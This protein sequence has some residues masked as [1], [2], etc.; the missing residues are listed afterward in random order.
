MSNLEHL[1]FHRH[2]WKITHFVVVVAREVHVCQCLTYEY[3][4]SRD[5][6]SSLRCHTWKITRFVVTRQV[7]ISFYFLPLLLLLW[8]ALYSEHVLE[9]SSTQWNTYE[10]TM[11]Y[12]L[13]SAS[14]FC[15]RYASYVDSFIRRLPTTTLQMCILFNVICYIHF[16]FLNLRLVYSILRISIFLYVFFYTFTCYIFYYVDAKDVA[17]RQYYVIRRRD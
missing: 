12:F 13:L 16:A 11:N 10:Q 6:A 15:C 8:Q 4:F 9:T 7:Q 5:F 17:R 2:T 14:V 3:T 1:T